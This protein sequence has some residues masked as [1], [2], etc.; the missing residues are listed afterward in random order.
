MTRH[1]IK[2]TKPVFNLIADGRKTAEVRFNDRLYQTG[3]IVIIH[4]G[5]DWDNGPNGTLKQGMV[6]ALPPGSH[7]LERRVAVAE[8]LSVINGNQ[9]GIEA[10]YVLLSL[11]TPNVVTYD[12]YINND[13]A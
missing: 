2:C 1:H 11:S 5:T 12:K 7:R 13:G 3:D 8:V 9:F 6:P 4:E 10:G